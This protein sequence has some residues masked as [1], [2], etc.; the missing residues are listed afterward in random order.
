MNVIHCCADIEGMLRFHNR[1][2]SLEG[3]FKNNET[4]RHLTDAEAREYLHACLE[5][6]WRVLPMGDCDNF[7]YQKGCLGHPSREEKYDGN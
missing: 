1:P 6:G 4:G 2:G 7:D 5:K 3:V